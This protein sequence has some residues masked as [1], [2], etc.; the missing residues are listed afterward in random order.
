M[1]EVHETAFLK[2]NKFAKT[3]FQMKSVNERQKKIL[4]MI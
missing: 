4:L 1:L 2:K 3:K